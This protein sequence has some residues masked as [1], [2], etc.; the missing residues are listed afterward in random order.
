MP[1]TP[2]HLGPS[3]WIGMSFL[4]IFDFLTL[5]I[6]SVIVDI[7]PSCVLQF[8]FNYSLH[9]FFHSFLGGSMVAGLTA[10]A[11]YFLKDYFK[12]VMAEFKLE[13]DSPLKKI[14]WTSFFGVYTHIL[15]D[16]PLYCDMRSFY[17]FQNNPFYGMFSSQ[18]IYLFCT[19]SFIMGMATYWTRLIV[20]RKSV[21]RRCPPLPQSP[22]MSYL[23]PI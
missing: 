22:R 3:F 15:L 6:A 19:F 7:E 21:N 4:R 16:A 2:Y 10:A 23:R 18:H 13:Q 12:K 1:L 20:K 5:L 9:G 11:M 8:D 14:L 17:P